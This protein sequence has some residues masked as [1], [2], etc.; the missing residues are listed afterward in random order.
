MTKLDERGLKDERFDDFERL[1]N[2][3][4]DA[5]YHYDIPS[6]QFLFVNRRF[7]DIFRIP[8][9]ARIAA[10]SSK[11][12]ESIHPEDLKTALNA[13]SDSIEAGKVEGEIEYRVLYP[14]GAIR[15]LHD[16]WAVLR[17]AT[18]SPLAVQGFIRDITQQ[19]RSEIQFIESKQ[20]API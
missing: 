6:K 19:Y 8:P 7:N 14:D 1:A 13:L 3:S 2:S 11:M 9:D 10:V 12:I 17:D 5:I 20:N 15:F 16:R 4:Q 18:G